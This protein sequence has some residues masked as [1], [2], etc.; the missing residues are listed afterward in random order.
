MPEALKG[1]LEEAALT[2]GKETGTLR[3][4]GNTEGH[5]TQRTP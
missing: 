1:V 3:S 5:S 4:R 2:L